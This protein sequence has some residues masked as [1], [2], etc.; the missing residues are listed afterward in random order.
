MELYQLQLCCPYKQGYQLC[1]CILRSVNTVRF[2][3]DYSNL[4][5]SF[6]QAA[7]YPRTPAHTPTGLR[8]VSYDSKDEKRGKRLAMRTPALREFV[9]PSGRGVRNCKHTVR[10]AVHSKKCVPRF[11]HLFWNTDFE[12]ESIIRRKHYHVE[13][14]AGKVRRP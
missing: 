3:T 10:Q 9:C 13:P 14:F 6:L 4:N 12:F 5:A 7:I 8:I 2:K 11:E 1:V